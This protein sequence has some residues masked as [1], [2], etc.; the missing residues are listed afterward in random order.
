MKLVIDA[1]IVISALISFGGNTRKLIFLTNFSLV[2][3]RYLLKE[4]CMSKGHMS[5][6]ST[7][8]NLEQRQKIKRT[9]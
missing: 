4:V 5:V 6:G 7:L 3:P 8:S 2:A 9:K 1:N